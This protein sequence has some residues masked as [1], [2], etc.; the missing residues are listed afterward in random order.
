M[1]TLLVNPKYAQTFWSFNKAVD[2]LNKKCLQPPLGLL[3]VAALMPKDWEME[4]AD[5]AV[6]PITEDQWNS[7]DTVFVT[8][9]GTQY[10]G[11]IRA[12]REG[13]K[14]GKTVV[15]GGPVVFHAPEDAFAAGADIVV[16]GEAELIAPQLIDAV[17]RKESRLLIQSDRRPD[18]ED[19]PTPRFDLLD[20][21]AYVDLGIQFSR[22]CPFKCEF[23]DITLMFGREVRTKRPEQVLSELQSLY[24]LGWRRMV[25][26]V[27]DNFIGNPARAKELLKALIPWMEERGYPFEFYT[28][29][30]V[31]LAKDD[32]LLE[33]MPKAGF[34]K[35]FLGIETLS[36]ETLK[37]AGKFQNAAADLDKVCQKI[38]GAGLQIIAGCIL[39][40]DD[41]GA[42]ADK[43]L[44]D[45]AV[46]NNIPEMFITLLQAGP[47]TDMWNRLEQEGRLLF[48]GFDDNFG[49]QTGMINFETKRPSSEIAREF[50]NLYGVLYEPDFYLDRTYNH[51]INMGP[52][53][54]TKGFSLPYIFEIRAVLIA[55]FHQ[56][57]VHPSR[58]KFWKYLFLTL[59]K[60]PDRFRQFMSA[61]VVAE[62]YYEYRGTIRELLEEQLNAPPRTAGA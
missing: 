61:C 12:I 34:C 53:P 54:Y 5:E 6:R 4:L 22:G 35:I 26:F 11:I 2:M 39:G 48:E 31:N 21:D 16:K 15:A 14:R 55:F 45:F 24:D 19:S 25:F 3:T 38:N 62:H 10:S 49:N 52:V 1:K 56:G 30:S 7:S 28:Q 29:A 41:E 46:R 17:N 43:H 32:A 58:F 18:L 37:S 51:I 33:L 9:L 23:C 36:K 50:I 42:G 20:L 60:R 59:F 27:D 13:K 44:I 57:V 8:G 40:F 47:G